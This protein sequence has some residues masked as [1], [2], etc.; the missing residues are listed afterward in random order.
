MDTHTANTGRTVESTLMA[1]TKKGSSAH[2]SPVFASMKA[3]RIQHDTTTKALRTN[4]NP[5]R[6]QHNTTTEALRIQHEFNTVLLRKHYEIMSL[7]YYESDG[8]F[9]PLFSIIGIVDSVCLFPHS[10]AFPRWSL[11]LQLH[12]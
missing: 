7:T 10:H 3:L 8:P 6:I 5:T 2:I 4:T 12:S 1:H 9:V 11:H